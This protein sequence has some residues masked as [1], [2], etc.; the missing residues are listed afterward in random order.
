MEQAI[1]A[2]CALLQKAAA[3]MLHGINSYSVSPPLQL[4][5]LFDDL[6]VEPPQDIDSAGAAPR[7]VQNVRFGE[8]LDGTVQFHGRQVPCNALSRS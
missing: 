2:V 5:L 1:T 8:S 4:N 7:P 6:G 3:L